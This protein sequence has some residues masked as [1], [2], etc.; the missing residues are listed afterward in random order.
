LSLGVPVK[1]F[2]EKLD[3]FVELVVPMSVRQEQ[4]VNGEVV[5]VDS[6]GNL[7]TNIRRRDLTG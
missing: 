4:Q 6:F 2:G 1:E 3:S 5:Y 7:F